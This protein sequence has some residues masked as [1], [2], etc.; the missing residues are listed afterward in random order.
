V[1]GCYV[2]SRSTGVGGMVRRGR[3]GMKKSEV[4]IKFP[5]DRAAISIP[6]PP[7]THDAQEKKMSVIRKPSG[8]P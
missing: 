7:P 6:H 4:E 3:G 8:H 1:A 5:K 2:H